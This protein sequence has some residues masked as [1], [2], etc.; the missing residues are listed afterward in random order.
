MRLNDG[1][2]IA[3]VSI[4]TANWEADKDQRWTVPIGAGVGKIFRIG[5]QPINMST[6]AYY[7]VEKPDYVGDWTLR[8][9]FQFMF[10]K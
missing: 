3:L 10:P 4:I 2:Y 5:K 8:I 7:N 6:H 9:Q 1:W